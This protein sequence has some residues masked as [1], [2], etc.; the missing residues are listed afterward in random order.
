MI[1]TPDSPGR[2]A[3]ADGQT[4]N[5]QTADWQAAVV[6]QQ[7]GDLAQAIALYRKIV[8]A[9]PRHA[10]AHA[11]LASCL[12]ASGDL[13]AALTA[14]GK[15]LA[16]QPGRADI[17]FNLGNAQRAAG[18]LQGA[19]EAFRK[20]VKREPG[21]GPGWLNLGV[22]LKA[23]DRDEEAL[24]AL[25][26]AVALLPKLAQAHGERGS[27]LRKLGRPQE[28]VESQRQAAALAPDDPQTLY[29]LANALADSE[30]I[31]EARGLY[32]R[33]LAL[34]PD[35]AEALVNL[36]K[37]TPPDAEPETV[38]QSAAL[39]ERAVA[40]R[41][42]LEAGVIA[43]ARHLEQL[44]RWPE[45]R[46]QFVAALGRQ[47][48]TVGLLRAFAQACARQGEAAE[49]ADLSARALACEPDSASLLAEW[50]M[51]LRG[52]DRGEEARERL[53][54]AVARSP[55]DSLLRRCLGILHV[56]AERMD[57]AIVEL[58]AALR[59]DPD[60]TQAHMA[61]TNALLS[62]GRLGEARRQCE[63][64]LAR[65]PD[66]AAAHSFNGFALVQQGHVAESM[67]SFERAADCDTTPD[68]H[69]SNLLFAA[70]YRDDR[71][72]AALGELHRRFGATVRVEPLPAPRLGR[73]RTADPDRRL[74]VGYVSPDLR[75]HSV[76]AFFEPLLTAHDRD[77]VEP[78]CYANLPKAD[79]VTERFKQQAALW[80]DVDGLEPHELAELIREDRIDILVDLAGHT[81]RNSLRAFAYK[82]AP[83]QATYIGYPNSTG[84]AAID[85][86][87]VDGITDPPGDGDDHYVE[88]LLRLPRCFLAYGPIPT[89]P[90]VQSLPAA[91]AGHVT[92]G[93]FNTIPK[94]TPSAVRL[95]A[96]V[97]A[98][99]PG[100]RL[101]LKAL[102]LGDPETRERMLSLF[103][104]EGIE[105]SRID[106]L[107]YVRG[108]AE[109]LALYSRIDIA[110]DSF[111]Y[112]GTTTTCEAL[113]MGVPVI[114]LRGERHAGRVGAS[115]LSAAGL[116]E[117]VAE[118]EDDYVARA[119]A[120]A[121]DLP[122]LAS[123]RQ[124]LRRRL[125]DSPLCD[126]AALARAVEAAYR[127]MWQR[128][129]AP[130]DRAT[131]LEPEAG[132]AP[133]ADPEPRPDRAAAAAE[134]E[135]DYQKILGLMAGDFAAA[136]RQIEAAARRWPDSVR[137]Q[138]TLAFVRNF[139]KDSTG[140]VEA[141]RRA[142][143]IE[144]AS[145]VARFNLGYCLE[146]LGRLDEALA[147][148]QAA[149]ASSDTLSTDAETQA[150]ACLHRLGR[151]EEAI[152]GYG[153]AL[154]ARPT[155]VPALYG[156]MRARRDA[157][158][159]D[160]A[161]DAAVR[162]RAL[163]AEHPARA[164][165]LMSWLNRYDF[166]GWSAL[167]D[168]AALLAE[169]AALRA[170]AG[171]G[172]FPYLPDSFLLPDQKAAMAAAHRAGDVWILK[173]AAL[174]GGQGVRLIDAP[175]A[176]PDEAGWLAQRYIADPLLLQDRKFHLRLYLLVA[177]IDPPCLALWQDGVVRFA[178]EPYRLDGGSLDEIARHVTNSA[179]FQDHPGMHL[180]RDPAK[181]DEGNVWS[182][183]ALLER[184]GDSPTASGDPRD[185]LLGLA[186]AV[187]RLI[188]RAGLFAAQ[189]ER[190]QR[191]AYPPKL[192]G[193]DVL[194][195]RQGR[196]WLLEIEAF[197]ALGGGAA[198][199]VGKLH[200]RLFRSAA[201]IAIA[202][203]PGAA[204][205]EAA[206]DG[207]LWA[208]WQRIPPAALLGD[209]G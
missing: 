184:L 189:R 58:E 60:D 175:A 105:R 107:A 3:A 112:N 31:E 34:R 111:P 160:R 17:L 19:A 148:Y 54:A 130:D 41:P 124:A 185:G 99:V 21:L 10:D 114:A 110:L 155:A 76:A 100:S 171:E 174:F 89:A 47:P 52:I 75:A 9:A 180:S 32:Q 201:A 129:L 67:A 11:N 16:L 62:I 96:R 28:A 209:G 132:R 140:A 119:Q 207:D 23:L 162:L 69:L 134:T 126:A 196:P 163:V 168:K 121:E 29:N 120:L 77:A 26:R 36:A 146:R 87:L 27:L 136:E 177:G 202:S 93:S 117:L 142:L 83:V 43:L 141:L 139:R 186:T 118:S 205:E 90:A 56:D 79:A 181:E 68:A 116:E 94:L 165:E 42:D 49:A 131:D 195:D 109:H 172:A 156:L 208:G 108:Q 53:E 169:V 15:A 144:P 101:L 40:A 61:L 187:A 82:P 57:D 152:A 188:D 128:A 166:H 127:G 104:A 106:L 123:L 25:E 137:A 84:L 113:W 8:A 74:R 22:A 102:S 78:V 138:L 1:E 147:Q 183:S 66:L 133:A 63:Q 80:R 20:A 5:G 115:L 95:W 199:V 173:P 203:D 182:L 72:A 7:G 200:D 85:Y 170:A 37:L 88:R 157:G 39:L 18:D 46:A 4:A 122:R 158:E 151:V 6:A 48:D 30:E 167:D 86:R 98:A 59:L 38:R 193:L 154:K 206:D 135:P 161:E 73:D 71:D 35:F 12:R 197:P 204:H 70:N 13:T 45:A 64:V 190:G 51:A 92:F 44:D 164:A 191:F 14:F 194:L 198:A 145:T 50:A 192:L 125:E 179:R 65:Q 2:E 176:A 150:A 143:E 81:A 149:A 153:R 55:D 33:A 91:E 97:L 159:A 178:V 103:A 24:A